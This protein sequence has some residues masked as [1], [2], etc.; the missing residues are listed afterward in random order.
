MTPVQKHMRA[1]AGFTLVELA[2]VMIIIG[3]LIAGVLKGQALIQNAQVT[4]T[5]AQVKSI[6]AAIST[7]SDTYAAIPGDLVNPA[8]RLPN[9][10]GACIQGAGVNNGNGH[11]ELTPGASP[12][13]NENEAFF[14]QLAT[15]GL[16]QALQALR[17][18][19]LQS[20]ATFRGRKLLTTSL[21]PDRRITTLSAIS[22]PT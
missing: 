14:P 8:T 1:Q 10:A 3:L 16:F 5:V 2:I 11:L 12:L 4:S 21:W 7:F 20:A 17:R 22:A 9:C 13:G 6:E 18:V 19:L 15:A